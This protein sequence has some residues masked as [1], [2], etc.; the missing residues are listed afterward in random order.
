MC[1]S[2]VSSFYVSATSCGDFS[3]CVSIFSYSVLSLSR[4]HH[5]ALPHCLPMEYSLLCLSS[6]HVFPLS[7]PASLSLFISSWQQSFGAWDPL[8]SVQLHFS[9]SLNYMCLLSQVLGARSWTYL[10]GEHNSTHNTELSSPVCRV[11]TWRTYGW[12]ESEAEVTAAALRRVEAH[13]QLYIVGL[14]SPWSFRERL[15]LFHLH[16]VL[17]RPSPLPCVTFKSSQPGAQATLCPLQF[18]LLFMSEAHRANL[19][20]LRLTSPILGL[21]RPVSY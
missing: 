6:Y 2:L 5:M 15:C 9:L 20:F 1:L 14:S 17:C 12:G 10:S 18:I 3:V 13:T 7:A 21:C 11:M 16:K 8:F 19:P 4:H